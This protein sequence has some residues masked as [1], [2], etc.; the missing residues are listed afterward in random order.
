MSGL[1]RSNFKDHY[2]E[3]VKEQCLDMIAEID[4][5]LVYDEML[6]VMGHTVKL[7]VEAHSFPR[8]KWIR[9]VCVYLEPGVYYNMQALCY[10]IQKSSTIVYQYRYFVYFHNALKHWNK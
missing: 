1:S 10:F 2:G 9:P 4:E 3:T 7:Q 5:F 6:W 8:Y